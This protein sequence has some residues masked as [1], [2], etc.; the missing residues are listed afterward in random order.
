MDPNFTYQWERADAD[1]SDLA[2]IPSASAKTYTLVGGDEG[3]KIRCTVTGSNT[4]GSHKASSALSA[5]I[6]GS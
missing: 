4:L 1:G 2:N 5:V 6:A 3:K